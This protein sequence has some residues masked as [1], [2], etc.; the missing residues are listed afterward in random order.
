[1]ASKREFLAQLPIFEKLYEDELEELARISQEY[2]FED[3]AVIAYQRDVADSL[4]IIR[5]GRLFAYTVDE[6]GVARGSRPYLAGDY[7]KDVWL[8]A[9]AAHD[10]TVKGSGSGRIIVIQSSDFLQFLNENPGVLEGLR[11][12]LNENGEVISG[13]SLEAWEAAQKSRLRADRQSAAI[14][15]LPDELVEYQ[16]RRS[17]WYLFIKIVGPVVGM[18]LVPLL[19]FS[20]LNNQV[21]GSIAYNARLITAI[22]L[23]FIFALIAAFQ[24]LDWSN[25]YFVIT[26]KH[27]AHREFSLT[28]FS[29]NVNKIPIDQ[30]QSVEIERPNLLANLFNFG[31]ARITTASQVGTVYFDNIDNPG[32]VQEII[33]ELRQRVRTLDAGRAQATMRQSVE[34]HFQVAPSYYKVEDED[35]KVEEEEVSIKPAEPPV[36]NSIW[37][38]IRKRYQWRVEENGVIT[39]R[40]HIFVL[41]K[42]AAW[43][44]LLGILLLLIIWL[45]TASSNLSIGRALLWMSPLL[46]L[47][48]AWLIWKVEDW[49]NDTFQLTDQYVVDIDRQPFGFGES[50]KQAELNNV[51]NISSDRPG[52]LPTIFNY[53]NV[54]IETAG[55]TADIVFESVSNPN[56]VQ[57]E[58][59]KRRD[60]YRQLLRRREGEQRRKEYA[61]LLDVYQQ[62]REQDLIPRRTPPPDE[63]EVDR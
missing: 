23:M 57:S 17:Y 56:R 36:L 45:I 32:R 50:R 29:T 6:R 61:V 33:N 28:R 58:V 43:P 13:L 7:F 30:I 25:D 1:M 51:Q 62:A 5:S 52:L 18:I 21:V 24:Y 39:Y 46:L 49:R 35:D 2:T 4:Y 38:A 55:A 44:V 31:T 8:F 54:I 3:D 41:L 63:V 48:F 42:I 47:D 16:A 34:S 20:Y 15:L 9:P 11:P 12:E 53:G 27:L 10:A 14:N 59:F 37:T 26:N 22:I 60:Q 40:K 19:A